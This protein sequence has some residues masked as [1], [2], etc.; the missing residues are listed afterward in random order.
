MRA[1]QCVCLIHEIPLKDMHSAGCLDKMH[2]TFSECKH[3]KH[4]LNGTLLLFCR[5]KHDTTR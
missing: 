2:I 5:K 3:C 4:A 1:N